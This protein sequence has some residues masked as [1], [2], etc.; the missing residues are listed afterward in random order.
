MKKINH[1]RRLDKLLEGF[2]F[3]YSSRIKNKVLI[4]QLFKYLF[5][6]G[7]EVERYANLTES[8]KPSHRVHLVFEYRSYK[9]AM[10]ISRKF[11]RKYSLIK[12]KN[13][14]EPGYVKVLFIVDGNYRWRVKSE[15]NSVDV[16]YSSSI[17]DTKDNLKRSRKSIRF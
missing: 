8:T 15:D 12:L 14:V 5:K 9:Y 7:I 11:P 2:S 4:K 1:I 17:D 3:N 10:E 13:I 6:N 16:I